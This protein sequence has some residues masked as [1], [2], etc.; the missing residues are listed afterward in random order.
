MDIVKYLLNET[1]ANIDADDDYGWTPLYG[2]I[3][4]AQRLSQG[5]EILHLL[6]QYGANVHAKTRTG[7]TPLMCAL[8]SDLLDPLYGIIRT[9]P[10]EWQ[11]FFEI[12]VHGNAMNRSNL[13]M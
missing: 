8:A 7:E 10:Q 5:N 9:R 4:N 11:T 6:L 3:M 13:C 1:T 12:S 2:A